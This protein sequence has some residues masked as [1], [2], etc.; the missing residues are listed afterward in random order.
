MKM[1][2]FMICLLA[3]T[4]LLWTYDARAQE[5]QIT[6]T[7]TDQ[8]NGE[9]LPGATITLKGTN[10]TAVVNN[11]GEFSI[12]VPSSGAVL[13]VSY[14][15]YGTQEITVGDKTNI[16]IQL[17]SAASNMNEVVVIGYGQVKKRDLT[18][19][20]VSIKGSETTRVPVTTPVEAL[21]G[22]V[23]GADIYRDNGY[24]GGGANIRIRG[25]RSLQNASSS[26][27]VL[28][29]VDGVQGVNLNDIN[30]NDIESI[31]ILKD[32]SSTAIYG[33]RGANGVMIVTTKRGQS[34]KARITF[35]TYAGQSEVAKYGPMQSGPEY[36]AFKREAYRA[37]GD[38]NS[39]ADD[40]KI[41]NQA[42]LDAIA[43]QQFIDWPSLILRHGAQ[44]DYQIGVSGGTE[45][46][47]VYFSGG[48]F[49]EKGLLR[50]DDFKRYSA[51]FNI[52]QTINNWLKAGISSQYAYIDNDKRRDPFNQASKSVP[53]GVPYDSAGNVVWDPVGRNQPSP[54][55]DEQP[56]QWK[57]NAK[58]SRFSGAVFVE[59]TPIKD[60]S[61]RSTFN[62]TLDNTTTGL[63][64]GKYTINGGG[65][66]SQS[67]ITDN[68]SSFISWENIAT[69]KKDFG[70][71]SFTLTGVTTYNQTVNTS[72]SGGGRNQVFPSQIY[73][74]LGSATQNMF[75]SSSYAKWNLLSYTGRINYAYKGKYL[76]TLTGR[77]D[78]SS[79]L[80]PGNKWAFFPSAAVAW[81]I[82]DEA[83]M[84][85]QHVFDDLKLRV[86][87]GISG[88]DVIAPYGTQ[89][90][91]SPLMF[92]YNDAD[93]ANAF[94]I[95]TLYG[96]PD[97]KWELTATT[98]IGLDF[99]L[100]KNRISGTID[101]YNARTYDLIFG[102]TLPSSTGY[103]TV[104][105]NIAETNNRGV[106]VSLTTRNIATNNFKWTST[107]S[108]AKN[109]ERIVSLPNGN[110]YSSDY[111]NSLIIG[112]PT[113]ILYDYVK[114]GIWQLGEEAEAAQFGAVPGDI[115][116]ADIS[117]P[118]GKHDGKISP[119]DRTIIGARVP[120]WTGGFNNDF[121]YKGFDLNVLFIARFGQWM[122]SDY[123]AK[124]YRN[125]A[126][127]GSRL[128]YWTPENPT[129]AYPR[130]NATASTPYIT[131]L[132]EYENSYIK[133]RNVTL[134][135]TFPK[136]LLNKWG[137]QGLRVYVSGKNLTFFSKN[138]KDFDP[139]SEGIIDQPLNKLVVGGLNLTL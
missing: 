34:G 97:L 116:I 134:G 31:D 93:P 10:K 48:Y 113:Q 124:Y 23:P 77:N 58:T 106:E 33:S 129:N 29:I 54:L 83:F 28:V 44:Q 137:I 121:S 8:Q 56:G 132:T 35:N 110:V 46:T 125:G 7:I 135:Y 68:Q 14:V 26:N 91:V 69:Y 111:R 41:F 130:P 79:K 38:W 24:A 109:R 89:G 61:I 108:Y 94:T 15:G 21:Q 115:K 32:A 19:A 107:I 102:Y 131:T 99:S 139:E 27:N 45:K 88:N 136:T 40:P 128:D 78:G 25:N 123:Y 71:H 9:P 17:S 81:R 65:A 36:I 74:N 51:R 49:H 22:K 118:D 117:G 11:Q 60:L 20:V 12:T 37:T 57:Q 52:D 85:K 84:D 112:Q 87:Y 13:V 39:P 95:N 105:R 104:N 73:W 119:E 3:I 43:K 86:G 4:G 127:N 16:P 30:P 5:K 47:K 18:G 59:L 55:A 64:Y 122:T 72:N 133:L 2:A 42:E 6:G 1:R 80:A 98:D 126:Q 50:L 67:Q 100:L 62:A 70:D 114:L 101:Y 92:S 103:Q 63:F 96:N 66:N 138:N 82:S 90:G 53:L 120:K 75:L 76:V